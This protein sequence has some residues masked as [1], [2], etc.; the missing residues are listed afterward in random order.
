MK[1]KLLSIFLSLSLIFSSIASMSVSFAE[2][3]SSTENTEGCMIQESDSILEAKNVARANENKWT[4]TDLNSFNQAVEEIKTKRDNDGLTDAT[5]VL[6]ED[7]TFTAETYQY[8]ESIGDNYFSGIENVT[9]TLTSDENGPHTIKRFGA[10]YSHNQQG[11]LGFEGAEQ[12]SGSDAR[13]L[14]GSMILDNIIWDTHEEDY[15]FAQGH[16]LVFTE[17]FKNTNVISVVGGNLGTQYRQDGKGFEGYNEPGLTNKGEKAAWKTVAEGVD[18]THLEVY[19]GNFAYVIAGGYNSD[20]KGDTYVKVALDL[21]NSGHHLSNLFGGGKYNK[22]NGDRT[23]SST[24]KGNTYVYADSGM[25]GDIFGGAE[26]YAGIKNCGVVQGDTHVVVGKKEGT[27]KAYFNNA[28]GG[29]LGGVLGWRDYNDGWKWK[30]GNAHITIEKTAEGR[31]SYGG[32]VADIMGGGARDIVNGTTEVIL[33]GGN[34]VHWVFAAGNNE[35]YDKTAHV[36]NQNKKNCAAKISVNGGEW[37]EIYSTVHTM[38]G[39]TNVNNI[40]GDVVVDFNGG[41]VNSFHLSSFMTHTLGDSILNVN[42]GSFSKYTLTIL[43]YRYSKDKGNTETSGKVDGKRIVNIANTKTMN[44]W[45][46]YAIDEINVNNTAP[47]IAKGSISEGALKDCG[48][49]NINSGIL[50]LTG[51]NNLVNMKDITG[52]ADVKGDFTIAKDG[53]LALNA[54]NKNISTPGCINAAGNA[55]GSG[56]LLVVKPEGDDWISTY[57]IPQNPNVGE[58]YLRSNTTDETAQENTRSNLLGLKNQEPTLYVEYTKDAKSIDNYAHAWRIAKDD[59]VKVL[60]VTFDKNGG[61]TESNP[62]SKQVTLSGGATSGVIDSLP[63]PPS[64]SG[65]TF[66]GWNTKNDGT[67]TEFTAETI[68]SQDITVY[69]KWEKE[70]KKYKVSYE[71]VNATNEDKITGVELDKLTLP[72]EVTKLLPKDTENNKEYSVGEEVDALKAAELKDKSIVVKYQNKDKEIDTYLEWKFD[73]YYVEDTKSDKLTIKKDGENKFVGK[74]ICKDVDL[75]KYKFESDSSKKLLDEILKL[76]PK[77]SG[78]LDIATDD[79][80]ELEYNDKKEIKVSDGTWNLV[81]WKVEY[82]DKEYDCPEN[83]IEVHDDVEFIGVWHFTPNSTGGGGTGGGTVTPTPNPNPTPNPDPEEP[84]RIEGNDR[85]ETSV[86]TSKDL[87]PNGTNAVVLA[88]AERYTDVLTADPF[89]IQEKASALLTY[90]YELPEKT[91]KE[92]ER[93]GAKK[94]YISGGYDAVS[95]K[96]VD[97]LAAKGYEIFRFDG[98][99]RYDT[100]RKIAI[101][102]REKGNT[103]AAELA[104]GE[105][106]PDALCMTPL[107]VKDHAPILLT[108]KDSIPKY[109]KQ[110]LAEWD[111]ENIKIGGLDEAVSP[112]VEKQL[113]SGFEIEKNNKKDSNVYDGAKAVKRIGGEDRYETSAKLAK[114]SYPESKL[115]V[116][117]T[118]EDFPDALIAGNYAGTKE[119]PVLLVKGDSL[120]EPIEKYTKESKIKKATIIGGVNAVSDKVFNLIKAIINR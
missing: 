38:V 11:Y 22:G 101:K 57:M 102:I 100:A 45:Q 17:N 64:R 41:K 40:N 105:D 42:G 65:Y 25:F 51:E 66:N 32:T 1:K 52:K 5:I 12:G 58:V 91:L 96:V 26:N 4:V 75:E 31:L 2:E 73:G 63:T 92:I 97:E 117:A 116:Y 112:E 15:I 3:N 79:E 33:N 87:Y 84:D 108:K 47:F 21:Q 88:N 56:K 106:F 9:L 104:S 115:G 71:F 69:A 27:L 35:S 44:C 111:I 53:V 7:I 77:T 85:I 68:V 16:N 76:V 50:A 70:A 18:S 62:T 6:T 34:K 93:L 107:A 114:E 24:V 49:V 10:T 120:P 82:K 113:K 14:I 43:G 39:T 89:A 74:W 67:G 81:E 48:N 20:V 109:T 54:T 55:S 86:E 119:A 23:T 98:V 90:K 29:S 30:G 83:P 94:I 118:G 19:G 80:V 99:D 78:H 59:S 28:Y 103:N 37:E 72:P 95:K 110:A 13:L 36:L 61:D 60:T 8:S 46:I